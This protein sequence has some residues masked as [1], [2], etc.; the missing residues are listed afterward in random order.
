M[1]LILLKLNVLNLTESDIRWTLD[2]SQT[3]FMKI[4]KDEDTRR[5]NKSLKSTAVSCLLIKYQVWFSCK[6]FLAFI[7]SGCLMDKVVY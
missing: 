5:R 6:S 7:F 2:E 4:L 1:C 3:G